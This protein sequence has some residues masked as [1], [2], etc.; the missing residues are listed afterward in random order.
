MYVEDAELPESEA[1]KLS[2]PVAWNTWRAWRH[3]GWPTPAQGRRS[4]LTSA[5]LTTESSAL[6]SL[7]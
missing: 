5:L 1:E 2:L 6:A 4:L 7:G 3:L